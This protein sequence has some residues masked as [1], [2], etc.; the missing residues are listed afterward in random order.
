MKL[1]RLDGPHERL[2]PIIVEQNPRMILPITQ[3][4]RLA[5]ARG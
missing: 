1:L 4:E 2:A 5:V 3:R